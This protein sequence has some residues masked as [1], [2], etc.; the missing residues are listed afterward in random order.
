MDTSIF[1]KQGF[2]GDD[3]LDGFLEKP[4]A[5]SPNAKL[6]KKVK[7]NTKLEV[8]IFPSADGSWWAMAVMANAADDSNKSQY[9]EYIIKTNINQ[10]PGLVDVGRDLRLFVNGA[11]VLNDK[12]YEKRWFLA[13]LKCQPTNQLL[14][15][16][17]DKYAA[18]ANQITGYNSITEVHENFQ[19][20]YTSFSGIMSAMDCKWL[21]EHLFGNPTENTQ[22]WTQHGAKMN[23]FW[24]FGTWN[25]DLMVYYGAPDSVLQVEEIEETEDEAEEGDSDEEGEE[26]QEDSKPAAHRN[27][28]DEDMVLD[29]ADQDD[30][31]VEDSDAEDGDGDF[32]DGE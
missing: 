2:S 28:D 29:D 26:E 24:P 15:K 10:F 14:K 5:V 32:E 18:N 23:S 11:P 13:I 25:R 21:A 16:L 4:L 3:D 7:V 19:L 9:V 1:K 6:S 17:L 22:Y 31:I 27:G 30:F 8:A 20:P 12:G